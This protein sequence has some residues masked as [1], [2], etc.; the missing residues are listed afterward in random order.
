MKPTSNGTAAKNSYNLR[1]FLLLSSI[2]IFISLVGVRLFFL[3]IVNHH[4]YQAMADNQH[5]TEQTIQPNRGEIYL[6]SALGDGKPVLVATNITKNLIYVNQKQITQPSTVAGKLAPLLEISKADLIPKLTGSSVY[7]VIKKQ[8]TDEVSEQI[9]SMNIPG[10]YLE[11]EIIRFYPEDN[12]ASHVIGFLGFKGNQRAGQ[13][14]V[15]GKF[16]AQLAGE[17]GVQSLDTDVAGRWIT[18]VDRLFVPSRDGNDIYLTLDPAIQFKAQE[19][20]KK[21]VEHHGAESGSVTVVD[22]KTGAILAMANYP[23]FDPNNYNKVEDISVYSN[24]ILSADYE[25]GSVFKSITMAAALDEGKVSP[26]TTYTDEGVVQVDDKQIK[27]SDPQP[28]GVQNMTQVMEKSLNTGLVFVQQQIG[29]ETFKK[30]VEKFGFGKLVDFPLPG[31]VIGNLDNLNRKGNIFFATAS[32]GQGITVTPLQ[33]IRAYTAIANGG[34]MLSPYI[35]N[36]IVYPDG[37]EDIMEPKKGEEII[38]S[39]TAATLSAM[40][41]NVVE[42]GHGKRAGVPDR[43]SVV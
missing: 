11:P 26:E 1:I 28:Q 14:G 3:Q 31:Q 4:H 7:T 6:S 24:K 21:T 33:L 25:P 41:V 20:L 27:N 15:E 17:A 43:K 40:L 19:V 16:E 8:L 2:L 22:P 42:N 30:Y 18:F 29:N 37:S 34:K 39:K 10:V 35:L 38:D 5:G 13:Y 32:Y 36:K 9:K 12:L 23:D